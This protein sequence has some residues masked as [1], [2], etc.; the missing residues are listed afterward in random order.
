MIN[1]I[2][3]SEPSRGMNSKDSSRLGYFSPTMSPLLYI[4]PPQ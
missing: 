4:S 3:S 1:V 2:G